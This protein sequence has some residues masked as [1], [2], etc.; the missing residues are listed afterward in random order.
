MAAKE[1]LVRKLKEEIPEAL[2]IMVGEG[3]F[4][5]AYGHISVRIPDT[6]LCCM[7][8]HIHDQ[9][10]TLDSI[11]ADDILVVDMKGHVREGALEPPGEFYIHTEIL[12]RRPD[13]GAVVHCH[14]K[15]PVTLS[16][17]GQNV[18]PV[19]IRGTIFA[20]EVPTFTDPTQID[21][22]EKGA[23]HAEKLGDGRAVV[24]RAHGVTCVGK[25]LMEATV[26]TID[27][28]EVA[29]LQLDASS[30]SKPLII[31]DKYVSGGVIAGLE[32]EFFSSAWQYFVAKY[33][34]R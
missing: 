16:I 17:A 6:G 15:A 30:I 34:D 24:L 33:R 9:Q 11:G 19:S 8:G 10:R 3:L 22:A 23:A 20:P 27:L 31:E 26:T 25:D 14:P 2:R 28:S 1:S 5:K 4:E 18:L 7:M 13:V 21:T 12:K 29:Q 32:H